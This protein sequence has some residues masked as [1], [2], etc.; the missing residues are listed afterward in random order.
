MLFIVFENRIFL[1]YT[2]SYKAKIKIHTKREGEKMTKDVNL[3]ELQKDAVAIFNQGFACSESVIYAIKKHFELDMSDDAIAMSSG[4]PWGLGGGGCI[5]GALAGGTMC[6]GYFLGRK[7][8]G[9]PKINKCF[10][11]TK[12][13]HDFFRETCGGT[14]CRILTKGKEKNSPERKEQCTKFVA[15]TVKKTAEIILREL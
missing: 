13:L 11:L 3:E 10:E 7:T 6:I 4:F 2:I 9:D 14:C 1:F 12:E 5:C 8:P 15:V